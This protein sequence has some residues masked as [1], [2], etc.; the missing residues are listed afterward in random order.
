MR[1]FANHPPLCHKIGMSNPAYRPDIMPMLLEAAE[2]AA[3]AGEVPVAAAVTDA[4]GAV[5]ALAQN[6]MK[7]DSN[8]LHHAEI[9][10]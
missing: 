9:G 5:L 4:G 7:Q 1:D 3:R 10:A 6:R 2:D 8:A